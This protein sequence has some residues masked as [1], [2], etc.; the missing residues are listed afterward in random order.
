[1]TLSKGLYQDFRSCT[2]HS[3]FLKKE[4]ELSKEQLRAKVYQILQLEKFKE[5][6]EFKQESDTEIEANEMADK[7]RKHLEKLTNE[8]SILKESIKN[9]DVISLIDENMK[10]QK[11]TQF[12]EGNNEMLL[13]QIEYLQKEN[14]MISANDSTDDG[15]NEKDLVIVQLEQEIQDLTEELSQISEDKLMLEKQLGY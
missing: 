12:L 6:P 11:D 8:V 10:R 13:R 15:P 9:L 1:M 14:L 7:L 5:K 2:A 3:Q 4:A